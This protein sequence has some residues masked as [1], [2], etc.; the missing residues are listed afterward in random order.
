MTDAPP[1]LARLYVAFDD[2]D[3]IDAAPRHGRSAAGSRASSPY[4]C[5]L[6]AVIR[7]QLLVHP[8]APFTSHNSAAVCVVD[9][10]DRAAARCRRWHWRRRRAAAAVREL[11]GVVNERAIR[12][13]HANWM[14]A[15]PRPVRSAGRVPRDAVADRLRQARRRGG[16][17]AGGRARGRRGRAPQRARRHRGRGHRCG[18]GRR[19]TADG[20]N[21][22]LIEYGSVLVTCATFG[23]PVSVADLGVAGI[24]CIDRP[25]GARALPDG[26]GEP[27]AV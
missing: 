13:L 19:L 7:Q 11:V 2:T 22:R 10:E 3:T 16:R 8:D 23:K 26:L 9:V 21:G 15:R 20:W 1:R 4:G 14:D 18:R 27:T 12:H 24:T 5:S 17:D 6:W 25:R